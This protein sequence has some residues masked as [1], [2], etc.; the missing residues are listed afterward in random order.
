[1]IQTNFHREHTGD[2]WNHQVQI[3]QVRPSYDNIRAAS[4]HIRHDSNVDLRVSNGSCPLCWW[5]EV[6]VL[7]LL[8][9]R[10]V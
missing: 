10:L 8:F 1:M 6:W 4:R 3:N 5:L 2:I 7:S 9:S